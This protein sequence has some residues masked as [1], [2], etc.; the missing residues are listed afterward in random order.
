MGCGMHAGAGRYGFPNQLYCTEA[1]LRWISAQR[2]GWL[3]FAV[4]FLAGLLYAAHMNAQ[5][6]LAIPTNV[7]LKNHTSC[8]V[9]VSWKAVSGSDHY[10]VRHRKVG[11]T[12]WTESGALYT[13]SVTVDGLLANTTYEFA[14]ASFCVDLTTQGYSAPLQKTTKKCTAP[15]TPSASAVSPNSVQITWL[16]LC[17]SSNFTL[18]YRVLGTTSWTKIKNISST[19][20]LLQGLAAGTTY[21]FRLQT[22]CGDVN[23]GWTS[24]YTVTTPSSSLPGKNI[25]LYILDDARYDAFTVNGGPGWFNTPAIT[26][27][28]SEGVNFRLT[29]PTTSQCSPSRASLYTG[30]Y[31]HVHG[32][33]K[34]GDAMNPGMPLI[35]QILKD[36][37]YHTGFVGK[38]GQF[39]G[40]P[41]GFNWWAT[42]EGNVFTDATYRINGKDTVITGHITDVYMQLALDFLNSVPQG[43]RFALFF[44]TRVPHL[45]A[46]PRTVDAAL[47]VSEIMPFP[48]NFVFYTNNYPSFYVSAQWSADS[49]QVREH[50]LKTFQS[51]AGAESNVAGLINW[52]DSKGLRDSTFFLISSDNGYLAGEHK[53]NEKILALEESIRVPLFIR[54]PP[55]FGAGTQIS[56]SIASNI[57]IA[58]TLLELAGL[59]NI[60]GFQGVSLR[61]MANGTLQRKALFYQTGWDPNYAKLRALRTLTDVFIRSYCKSTCEEFY[62]LQTDPQ[63][64]VNQI[65]NPVY[66]SVISQRKTTL[67]SL[68]TVYGDYT[69]TKKTCS[70]ITTS[71]SAQLQH[72]APQ[73]VQVY[74][75]PQPG[76]QHLY[77]QLSEPAPEDGQLVISNAMGQIILRQ[78]VAKGQQHFTIACSQWTRGPY[79]LSLQFYVYSLSTLVI[80]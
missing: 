22:D 16:A 39:L 63:Q 54:Y 40:D 18:Q 64:N 38:Y 1:C 30:V 78:F 7:K 61:A 28:A 62:D 45:P 10:K 32:V 48:S 50:I 36:N 47:F 5:C 79:Y 21:E 69:P 37:G 77:V 57:D 70:L 67:D 60:Y 53:M 15:S 27:I 65:F 19:S 23:S 41:A 24:I 11:T 35:Q 66:S 6:N 75:Y 31:A 56:N 76:P 34:N 9:D 25:V 42:S 33:E 52:L 26:S 73:I 68:R 20:Y 71:R 49:N 13:T 80:I 4:V 59:P 12:L 51:L 3:R 44:L 46:T 17:G 2:K 58:P 8:S 14:V 72:G 55:W 43:K 29:I 74:A